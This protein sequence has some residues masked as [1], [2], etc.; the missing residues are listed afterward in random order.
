LL[1]ADGRKAAFHSAADDLVAGDFNFEADLFLATFPEPM[2]A[3][4][5][6]D[7]SPDAYERA[8][9][10]E[11]AGAS[12]AGR[13]AKPDV[14]PRPRGGC[15]PPLLDADDAEGFDVDVA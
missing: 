1:S 3:D 12:K 4:S 2:V 14:G 15:R 8:V 6:G 5:D 11:L 7:G 10:G 9:F 13:G